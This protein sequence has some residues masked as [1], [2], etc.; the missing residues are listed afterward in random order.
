MKFLALYLPQYH[1]IPENDY[2]WG[3]GYTEWTAVRNAKPLYR[4]H[5]QPVSPLNSNYYD[6]SDSKAETWRWQ[7][8]LLKKYEIYGFCIYH[9]WFNGRKLLEK[10]IEILLQ[11]KD[12]DLNYCFCWANES[13]TR[14][15][16][17]KQNEILMEQQY[18]DSTEWKAHYEY[19]RQFF[20]DSRYIKVNNAPLLHIYRPSNIE[21]LDEMLSVWNDLARLDGFT[22]IEIVVSKNGTGN[23]EIKSDFISGQYFFEPGYSM[24]NGLSKHEQMKYFLNVGARKAINKFLRTSIIEHKIDIREVN[25]RII[26]N[27]LKEINK[28]RYKTYIGV[29][30]RWDNTPRRGYK[31]IVYTNSTPQTFNE[32]LISVRQVIKHDDFVYLNAWNEWGEGCFMEPD[33]KYRYDFLE[34]VKEIQSQ[35]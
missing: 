28:S 1:Q 26:K 13:W 20:F 32:L 15:W 16:Y 19:L 22:K 5:Q 33:T 8:E 29:C 31:G 27:Y 14:T 9:Y 10:P 23:K 6:L 18:G 4:G 3:Q 25:N 2:W 21:Q 24:R 7:S 11:N 34:K 12:I 35:E 17:D 30:P